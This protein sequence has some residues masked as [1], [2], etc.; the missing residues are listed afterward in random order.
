MVLAISGGSELLPQA[1]Y[2]FPCGSEEAHCLWMEAPES[3][4]MHS[5]V[6]LIR[7]KATELMHPCI[8]VSMQTNL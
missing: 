8:S 1:C 5:W 6:A 4:A 2:I 7:R 3:S